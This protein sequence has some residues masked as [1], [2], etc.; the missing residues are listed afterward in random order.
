MC[1]PS[2]SCT[3][4][5]NGALPV[6]R[7]LLLEDKFLVERKGRGR[8][9]RCGPGP[10]LELKWWRRALLFTRC[11]RP[12]EADSGRALGEGGCCAWRPGR[13]LLKSHRQG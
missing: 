10:D 4:C 13:L 11:L 8:W 7:G 1:P 12:R 3:A 5:N 2:P 9:H 6:G